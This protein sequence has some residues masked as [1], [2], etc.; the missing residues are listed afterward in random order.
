LVYRQA[1]GYTAL[2][3]LLAEGEAPLADRVKALVQPREPE[4]PELEPFLADLSEYDELLV[5]TTAVQ[6]TP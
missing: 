6:V 3:L 5:D 4:V 1:E 2:E